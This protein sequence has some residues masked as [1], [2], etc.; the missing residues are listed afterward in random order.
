MLD[1]YCSKRVSQMPECYGTGANSLGFLPVWRTMA[2]VQDKDPVVAHSRAVLKGYY[3]Y[4]LYNRF[5]MI[6]RI[7]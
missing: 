7:N 5:V 2:S 3:N 4:E 6:A 1:G